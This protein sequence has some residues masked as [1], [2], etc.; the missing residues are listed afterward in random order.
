MHV[1]ELGL[2]EKV[3]ILRKGILRVSISKPLTSKLKETLCLGLYSKLETEAKS[4]P[5]V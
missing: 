1:T 3:L 5:T 2:G 4:L